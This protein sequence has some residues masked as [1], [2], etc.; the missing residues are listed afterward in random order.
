MSDR[1]CD[2]HGGHWIQGRSGE[3][4][5]AFSGSF[6]MRACLCMCMNGQSMDACTHTSDLCTW[7]LCSCM[8]NPSPQKRVGGRCIIRTSAL[9][10]MYDI[11]RVRIRVSLVI[12]FSVDSAAP[13]SWHDQSDVMA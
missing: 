5:V 13:R 4:H 10:A 12:L 9:D 11:I 1:L 3:V 6:Y 8:Q 2:T 7:V